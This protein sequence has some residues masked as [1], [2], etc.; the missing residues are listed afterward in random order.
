M[1]ERVLT[2]LSFDSRSD[3]SL[4]SQAVGVFRHGF[5]RLVCSRF[6]LEPLLR[7]VKAHRKSQ[8]LRGPFLEESE[9]TRIAIVKKRRSIVLASST[10]STT[11]PSQHVA[12]PWT[13]FR[14]RS[15]RRWWHATRRS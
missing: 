6:F 4:S 10:G 14:T 12:Q 15:S 2:A 11:C 5:I 3:P 7:D 1:S 8:V 13:I 9:T